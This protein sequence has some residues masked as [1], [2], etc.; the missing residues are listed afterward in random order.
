M[1]TIPNHVRNVIKISKIKPEEIEMVLDMIATT[2]DD[3]EFPDKQYMIDFDKIIPEP[4]DESECPD[5]YKVNKESRIER[6]LDRPWFDWYKWH[7]DHWGTKWDAYD[8]YTNV[9]KTYIQFVFSTAWSTPI[10]IIKK[11]SVLGYQID[12]KYADEDYGVNCGRLKYTSEQ[13]WIHLNSVDMKDPV[14]FAKSVW[15]Y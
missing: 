8:C 12:V 9:G 10:P 1:S 11:L 14:R 13:G 3:P 15:N 6:L 2:L 4:K 5:E 7:I